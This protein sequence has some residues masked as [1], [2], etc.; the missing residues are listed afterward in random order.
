MCDF[1]TLD[2]DRSSVQATCVPLIVIRLVFRGLCALERSLCTG[3]R[4]SI[5]SPVRF[6]RK[7]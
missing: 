4:N 3:S 5:S 1:T 6:N 7:K 2:T